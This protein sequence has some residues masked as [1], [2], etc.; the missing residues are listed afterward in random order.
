MVVCRYDGHPV[1]STTL[2][3]QIDQSDQI[4]LST[5]GCQTLFSR[6]LGEGSTPLTLAVVVFFIAGV[7]GALAALIVQHA[8]ER[9]LVLHVVAALSALVVAF[10][11]LPIGLAQPK[12]G[13]IEAV[14]AT[15]LT[16]TLL[17]TL[18]WR[19]LFPARHRKV[20]LV[21]L[22][23]LHLA[24]AVISIGRVGSALAHLDDMYVIIRLIGTYLAV[25]VVLL[26][27]I[28]VLLA[29]FSKRRLIERDYAR[30]LGGGVLIALVPIFIFGL[31]PLITP[32]PAVIDGAT[33]SVTFIALPL[34][35]AYV[36]LKSELLKVDSFVRRTVERSLGI[37]LFIF[38]TALV[39]SGTAIILHISSETAV[40]LI[41]PIAIMG[42]LTAPILVLA[43]WLTETWL[44]PQ[45]RHFR[46][47]LVRGAQTAGILSPLDIAEEIASEVQ[48]A[49]PVSD[50]AIFIQQDDGTYAQVFPKSTPVPAQPAS[51]TPVVIP[52]NYPPLALLARGGP[53][54][55]EE[56]GPPRPYVRTRPN[57]FPTSAD[58]FTVWHL[59][60]PIVLRDRLIGFVALSPRTDGQQYSQTDQQL[61]ML[62]VRRHSLAL[63]YA[64]I[65]SDLRLSLEQQKELDRLKDQFIMTAHH[66][67]RT[68]LSVLMGYIELARETPD[69]I[70]EQEDLRYYLDQ[71]AGA[72]ED[73]TKLLETMLV[74]DRSALQEPE[75][76]PTWINLDEYIKLAVERIS[77]SSDT[78][79]HAIRVMTSPEM[80]VWADPTQVWMILSN[81]LTNAM[82]YSA[83]DAPIHIIA[84]INPFDQTTVDVVVRD[85]GK[86][87]PLAD[88]DKIFQ[89]FTRLERDINSSVRGTGL[90]LFL[91]QRLV[92]AMGGDMWVESTGIPGEGSAFHFTLPR[93]TGG[94]DQGEMLT[95]TKK[96]SIQQR[97]ARQSVP[98]SDK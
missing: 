3:T 15:Y 50:V 72:G 26:S 92:R 94:H 49:L 79:Q 65:L 73:L 19:L 90:G 22:T 20:R 2:A 63:D 5:N 1:Q 41:V 11:W 37:L 24:S 86:G 84:Q 68:P 75:I 62:L 78:F 70:K 7:C 33:A 42:I 87:I 57:P 17:A 58:P 95:P 32:L 10:G 44:F 76:H 88:Q 91:A 43:R 55:R 30:I 45:I 85:W 74:A 98:L 61:L 13:E 38:V 14:A 36:I 27:I 69:W 93:D 8:T 16:S 54:T 81:L 18:I 71:A 82:K 53:L 64:R 12:L 56:I 96:L 31:L 35:M 28:F 39:L 59:F 47:V 77:R 67:L 80:K 52:R 60:V 97:I 46:Q 34:S 40:A 66:E 23:L 4:S 48:L 51:P 21:L 29:I 9:R 83:E 89:K 6:D 25:F